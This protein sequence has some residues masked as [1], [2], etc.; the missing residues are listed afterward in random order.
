MPSYHTRTLD[1]DGKKRFR[2]D[3]EARK[4]SIEKY[5]LYLGLRQNVSSLSGLVTKTQ[6]IKQIVISSQPGS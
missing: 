3:V 1:L 4:W 5:F 2:A 6:A